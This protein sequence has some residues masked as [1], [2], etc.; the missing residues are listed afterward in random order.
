MNE[1]TNDPSQLISSA[2][3]S[4]QVKAKQPFRVPLTVTNQTPQ[5]WSSS[6]TYPIN[7]SYR[8]VGVNGVPL[9]DEGVRTKLPEPLGPGKSVDLDAVVAPPSKQGSLTLAFTMVQEGSAWFDGVGGKPLR[10]P[11]T[12]VP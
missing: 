12:V 8:W 1:K 3:V 7:L 5:I 6:G 9:P 4:L 11:V 10:I 2:I